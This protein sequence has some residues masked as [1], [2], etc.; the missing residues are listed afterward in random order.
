MR[1]VTFTEFRKNASEML[2]LVEGGETLCISRH[3]KTVA[4]IVPDDA[5]EHVP[6]WKRPGL[7][8]KIPGVSLSQAI[9]DE[10]NESP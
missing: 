2:D 1:T 9:I 6:T 10:R 3:G 5:T 4:R 7:R 8:L